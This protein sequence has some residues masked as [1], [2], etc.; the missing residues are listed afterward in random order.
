MKINLPRQTILALGVV[1]LFCLPA[2]SVAVDL[3][4]YSDQFRKLATARSETLAIMG[5]DDG[6]SGGTYRFYDDGTRMSID[7]KSTRLNSSH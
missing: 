7:R 3:A 5:G 4:V 1:A 2:P 6:I